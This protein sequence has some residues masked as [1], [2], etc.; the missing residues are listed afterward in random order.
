[1]WRHS[2]RKGKLNPPSSGTGR[3]RCSGVGRWETVTW[4]G[5]GTSGH[6]DEPRA[7]FWVRDPACVQVDAVLPA[8]NGESWR[9]P[10]PQAQQARSQPGPQRTHHS[11]CTACSSHVG[12]RVAP[13]PSL[14]A[15]EPCAFRL[16][17]P[18]ALPFSPSPLRRSHPPLTTQLQLHLFQVPL[19]PPKQ[20]I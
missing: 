8:E 20:L 19:T 17:V 6:G 11:P 3:I 5:V 13:G 1:M 10:S 4:Q 14:A 15:V 9:E 7:E 18:A 12:R 16:G 2:V